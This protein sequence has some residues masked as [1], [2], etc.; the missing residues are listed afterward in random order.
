MSIRDELIRKYGGG[1]LN[2]TGANDFE[3]WLS[4]YRGESYWIRGY[5]EK[6]LNLGAL[7]PNRLSNTATIEFK[8]ELNHEELN[9]DYQRL[10]ENIERITEYGLALGGIILKPYP[11]DERISVDIV[12]PDMFI[13]LDVDNFGLLSRTLF[14]DRIERHHGKV[15]R[16]YTRVEEHDRKRD[17]YVITNKCYMSESKDLLGK[18]I[19]LNSVDIWS[20]LE[21][22]VVV[23]V[24]YNLFGYFKNPQANN[25]DLK[26]SLGISCFA[27]AISLIQDADEQYNRLLWEYESKET[28]IDADITM[29]KGNRLPKHQERL[30]RKLNSNDDFYE[31]YSPTIRDES[32]INGLNEILKKIEDICGLNRGA[33]SE[34][35]TSE[36]TASEIIA[37]KQIFYTT[38]TA[39][40]NNM[41]VCLEHTVKA[42]SFWAGIQNCEVGFE[43]DDS[44]LVDSNTEREIRLEEV[45]AGLM[46]PETYVAWRYGISEEEALKR[47]PNATIDDSPNEYDILERLGGKE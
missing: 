44:I 41:Q 38:V 29:F 7:I 46:K 24:D 30:F 17:N 35:N 28:A 9:E 3:T 42:M 31:V 10:I 15:T 32:I 21:E 22:A 26:S 18:E 19:E 39:I 12:T 25:L 20:D 45:A 27:R 36:R 23:D 4:I 33:L 11:S 47:L 43:W 34:V 13:P 2:N 1:V 5:N 6:S 16:Y 8:S 14:L 40:Q 37:N